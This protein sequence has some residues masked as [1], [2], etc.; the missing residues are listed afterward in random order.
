MRHVYIYIHAAYIP[1]RVRVRHAFRY[2]ILLNAAAHRRR[3]LSHCRRD[4]ACNARRYLIAPEIAS[5]YLA[6]KINFSRRII[7]AHDLS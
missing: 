5:Q 6:L 3:H 7:N 4:D 2:I 1:H